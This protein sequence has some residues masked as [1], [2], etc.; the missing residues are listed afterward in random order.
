MKVDSVTVA[1]PVL[2]GGERF[3]E[4]LRAVGSQ[5]NDAG[6]EFELLIV[7][8]GSTDGSLEAA[9]GAGAR[10]IEIDKSTFQHGRTRNLA[11]SEARGDVV[12]LLTD[13]SAPAGPGWLD[14]IVSSFELADDVALVFGPQLALPEHSLA[15]R[16]EMLDHFAAWSATNE[17]PVIQRVEQTDAGRADYD[18][19]QGWYIFF[20]DANG[21]VARWAWEQHPYEEVPYAEDQLIARSMIEAG[22]AKV[23]A[24]GAAVMHSHDYPGLG[25]L[26]RYFD[27]FRGLHEVMGY[28]SSI[29]MRS[30]VRAVIGLTRADRAFMR[31]EGVGGFELLRL[32]ALSVRRH[33]FRVLGE[34][35][36]ARADRLPERVTG[37]LSLEGRP[38]FS[39]A[40]SRGGPLV[41]SKRG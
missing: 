7:D 28:R 3:L 30:G 4:L 33:A 24:P 40:P 26:H 14:A 34:W 25:W 32:T 35:T 22:F 36:A 38:G 10:V 8:S 11:M 16:R 39:P 5:R 19:R 29:G 1:V 31:S 41:G 2:N 15:V 9:R 37:W 17:S 18:E 23:F 13:D 6:V 12:A 27:D 21:A 20:S